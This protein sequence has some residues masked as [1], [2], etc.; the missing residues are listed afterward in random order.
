MMLRLLG[1]FISEMALSNLAQ[2][3]LVLSPR[4]RSNPQWIA[5]R[6]ELRSPISRTVLGVMISMTPGTLTCD[7]RGRTIFIHVLNA[8]RQEDHVRRIRDRFESLLLRM[9]RPR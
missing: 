7:L 9:E 5:F 8:R 3:R 4:L 2:A 1:R 6:T